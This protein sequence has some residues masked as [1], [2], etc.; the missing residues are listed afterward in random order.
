MADMM[1]MLLFPLVASWV[2][3]WWVVGCIWWLVCL[4]FGGK[5]LADSHGT[6]QWATW[7]QLRKAGHFKRQG[8]LVGFKPY[9][10]LLKNFGIKVYTQPQ[11][12]IICIAPKGQ[13]KTLSLIAAIRD[14]AQRGVSMQPDLLVFDPANDIEP[15][16]REYCVERG[17]KVIILDLR[18]PARGHRYNVLSILQ[19]HNVSFDADV[20]Q[21]T[22]LIMPDD[23]GKG[24]PHFQEV[25]RMLL[26]GSIMH[27]L[28]A[29]GMT[30]YDVVQALTVDAAA[31]D[32][33]FDAMKVNANPRVRQAVNSFLAAGE[34]E[35]GSFMTTMSRK[36][37]VWLRRSFMEM[38][39]P[40]GI[41]WQWEGVFV[42]PEPV[43]T[44]V[45]TGLQPEEGAFARLVFG[46]AINTRR[47]MFNQMRH[48]QNFPKEFGLL[49]DEMQV[50]GH[51]NAIVDAN[52][53]LR[54]ARTST[55]TT[56]LSWSLLF[57]M[58]PQAKTLIANSNLVVFGGSNDMEAYSES[59]SIIGDYTVESS[60]RSENDRGES[61]SRS[62]QGRRLAK[63]DELRRLKFGELLY[64]SGRLDSRLN[65]AWKIGKNGVEFR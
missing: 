57:Q 45:I 37:Q 24:E 40:N 60:S 34:R 55:F 9:H 64:L 56:F 30:L 12:S 4:P 13:G 14:C 38:T 35:R 23:A 11:A 62:E 39:A 63:A 52:N 21:I 16:T 41:D 22:S 48:G 3:L 15:A 1:K 18:E 53:E 20:D 36:L 50:M 5:K 7:K 65:T 6:A 33:L 19:Q 10:R 31:R 59:S 47:R 46:N 26:A 54:K 25:G 51:C 49:A 29:G 27:V 17:Y 43:I 32:K 61:E 42:A 2:A 58:Y 8:W 44:Y 28:Q